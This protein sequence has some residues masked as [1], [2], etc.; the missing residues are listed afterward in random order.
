MPAYLI[1]DIEI[2][3][4]E[5]YEEY[6]A[7]VPALIAKHGGKY[8]VRGGDFVVLEGDWSPSRLIVLEF[9]DRQAALAFY[10]DPA[11][12]PYKSLRHS[13]AGGSVIL[14]DGYGCL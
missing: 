11:Y 4:P 13:A 9:P 2:H 6:V 1:A 8:R 3:D 14:A 12:A 10:E 5:R 7:H